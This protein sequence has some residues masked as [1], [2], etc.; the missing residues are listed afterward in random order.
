MLMLACATSTLGASAAIAQDFRVDTDVMGGDSDEILVETLTIFSGDVVYD[1]LL[2]DSQEIT[3]F[4]VRR[5]RIVVLDPTRRVKTTLTTDQ[6]LEFSAHIKTIAQGRDKDHLFEPQFDE[7]FNSE[8][9]EVEL[10]SEGLTYRAQGVAP[11]VA[12]APKRY[13][14]FADWYARLNCVRAPN[15]PPFGRLVLNAVLAKHQLVPREVERIVVL[16]RP[17]ANKQLRARSRHS[18]VWALSGTDRNRI[19]Q[20]A[21]HNA[22]F[23]AVSPGEYWQVRSVASNDRPTR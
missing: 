2:T 7:S 10:L 15:V 19:E 5:G 12:A 23:E 1:F 22:N 3:V 14:E 13:R 21:R 17:L 6:L 16:D 4:D 20:A 11:K 8:T 18:F 9:G